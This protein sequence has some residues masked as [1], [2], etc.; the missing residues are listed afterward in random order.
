MDISNVNEQN[1]SKQ[2]AEKGGD[3]GQSNNIKM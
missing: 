3:N 2:I 1:S